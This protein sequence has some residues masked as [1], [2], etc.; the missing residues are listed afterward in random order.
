MIIQ[1]TTILDT[2]TEMTVYIIHDPYNEYYIVRYRHG[3]FIVPMDMYISQYEKFDFIYN[4]LVQ[5]NTSHGFEPKIVD[6][7]F[8]ALFVYLASLQNKPVP[9]VVDVENIRMRIIQN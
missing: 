9:D 4:T 8:V 3:A 7:T 5:Y 1:Q 2:S 6:G